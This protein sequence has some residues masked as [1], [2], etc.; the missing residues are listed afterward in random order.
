MPDHPT[1]FLGPLCFEAYA[2]LTF[3]KAYARTPTTLEICFDATP[4]EAAQELRH[5]LTNQ[6]I[7]STIQP[8]AQKEKP[9]D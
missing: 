8:Q 5:Y 9:H 7:S 6:G 4:A 1:V 2:S 3:R